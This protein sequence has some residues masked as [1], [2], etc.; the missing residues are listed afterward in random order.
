M[1]ILQWGGLWSSHLSYIL[2]PQS[3]QFGLRVVIPLIQFPAFEAGIVFPI[4]SLPVVSA[5]RVF[6]NLQRFYPFVMI[7][8]NWIAGSF[9]GWGV[10]LAIV[11]YDFLPVPNI[12]Y[13]AHFVAMAYSPAP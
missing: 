9:L 6:P 13:P 11:S 2:L 1:H 3:F 12:V 5:L 4:D 7:K 8:E 10:M